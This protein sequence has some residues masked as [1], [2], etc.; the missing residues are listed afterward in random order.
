[1]SVLKTCIT[2][3]FKIENRKRVSALPKGFS[4]DYTNYIY[5]PWIFIGRTDAEAGTPILWP[6][7]A[8]NWLIGKDPDA[9]KDWR[10]EVKGMTEDEMVGWH[11]RLDGHEFEQTLGDGEGQGSQAALQ[12]LGSQRVRYDWATEQQQ[13]KHKLTPFNPEILLL[14]I[15]CL[16]RKIYFWPEEKTTNRHW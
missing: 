9:G 11:H 14:G 2:S 12:S 15:S 1:M 4:Y 7:D 8:K 5:R 16:G 3:Q 13:Y 10:Q 6:L